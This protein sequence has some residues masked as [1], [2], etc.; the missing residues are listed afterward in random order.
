MLCTLRGI[1]YSPE[2]PPTPEGSTA[3]LCPGDLGAIVDLSPMGTRIH[4]T[5]VGKEQAD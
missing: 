2:H 3:T 1:G 5:E 4:I